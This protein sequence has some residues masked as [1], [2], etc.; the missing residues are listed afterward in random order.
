MATSSTFSVALFFFVK[1]IHIRILAVMNPKRFSMS[2]VGLYDELCRKLTGKV[3]QVA[4]TYA[5]TE[6]IKMRGRLHVLITNAA[7]GR[8]YYRLVIQESQ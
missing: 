8:Q 1:S 3:V 4:V 6:G 5:M 7:L 2:G